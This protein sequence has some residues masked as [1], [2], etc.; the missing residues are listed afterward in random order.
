[1]MLVPSAW[2]AR[3]PLT[4]PTSA[5]SLR[6]LDHQNFKAVTKLAVYP[7]QSG[8]VASNENTI[9][10]GWLDH[11][12][13]T[14]QVVYANETPVG[15]L[16]AWCVPVEGQFHLLRFMIDRDHQGQDYGRA[17]LQQW[18]AALQAQHGPVRVTLY[19]RNGE[20]SPRPFYER[21][22][23]MDTGERDGEEHIMAM[24]LTAPSVT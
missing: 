8:F 3:M 7:Y 9:A 1:M 2:P 12:K 6:A 19:Y 13:V 22:G 16:A 15:L 23:F 18:L 17:A 10:K 11:D 5:V 24:Q 14:L 4:Q 21:L 20:G